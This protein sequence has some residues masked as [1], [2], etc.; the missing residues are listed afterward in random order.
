MGYVGYLGQLC[1][2]Y[3]YAADMVHALLTKIR[4]FVYNNCDTTIPLRDFSISK[5]VE[6]LR[7]STELKGRKY[8]RRLNRYSY[9]MY[10]LKRCTK[11]DAT[12]WDDEDADHTKAVADILLA[13]F[14]DKVGKCKWGRV[15]GLHKYFC[16]QA[17]HNARFR[18]TQYEVCTKTLRT[19]S[20][21]S[22]D[23]ITESKAEECA[24]VELK[25][26]NVYGFQITACQKTN[27]RKRTLSISKD[28]G[29]QEPNN[30]GE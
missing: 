8:A 24:L 2:G 19:V 9:R 5:I 27:S 18:S 28:G 3:V 6:R 26:L 22:F 25:N 20:T 15:V 30:D 17:E 23:H 10:F 16:S 7:G 11:R 14:K 4:S 1:G 13:T 12:D 29:E 21:D